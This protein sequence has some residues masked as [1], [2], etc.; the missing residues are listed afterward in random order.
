[1]QARLSQLKCLRNACEST[2]P[3]ALKTC[4]AL[5]DAEV[6]VEILSNSVAGKALRD[7]L[8]RSSDWHRSLANA[9]WEDRYLQTEGKILEALVS[10]ACPSCHAPFADFEGCCSLVCKACGSNFCALC[11][12]KTSPEEGHGHVSRCSARHYFKMTDALF[13]GSREWAAGNA[14]WLPQFAVYR[15][16]FFSFEV[17]DANF[18]LRST[19]L[20][21]KPS[22]GACRLMFQGVRVSACSFFRNT[23]A[24]SSR[25]KY[26]I[27]LQNSWGQNSAVGG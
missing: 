23:D 15:S 17:L 12:T 18:R 26:S 22:C 8:A 25:R 1:M 11:L 24:E 13:C 5:G 19:I 16:P 20:D 3:T 6:L 21:W 10:N 4:L 27:W 14:S 7:E 2:Y 9:S